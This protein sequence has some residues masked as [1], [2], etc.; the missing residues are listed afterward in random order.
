MLQFKKKK[1]KESKEASKK[2]KK[3]GMKII[4]IQLSTYN[5]ESQGQSF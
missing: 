1:K 4:D 5:L 3:K 2:K